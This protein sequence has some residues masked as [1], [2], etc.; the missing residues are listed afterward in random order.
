MRRLVAAGLL[1]GLWAA[2]TGA[3]WLQF[4]SRPADGSAGITVTGLLR[5]PDGEGPFPVAVLL[6]DCDGISPHER[7]WGVRFAD[8]GYVAYL[9][10][11]FFTRNIDTSCDGTT[12]PVM[13]DLRGALSRLA[14]LG[15]VDMER[16]VVVGWSSGGDVALAWAAEEGAGAAV[17]FYPSCAEA[18]DPRKPVLLVLPG[19]DV[20]SSACRDHAGEAERTGTPPRLAVVAPGAG[21]GFDCATCAER[22]LGG[23]GGWN[24]AAD[25]MVMESLW[26]GIDRLLAR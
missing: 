19:L 4:Q 14:G 3:T 16:I 2:T 6:A 22:Y 17:A 12:V 20:G 23:P 21:A 7:D 15:Y 24:A 25:T 13:D 1:L 26:P 18:P 9:L 8:H 11:S 10:D 5:V